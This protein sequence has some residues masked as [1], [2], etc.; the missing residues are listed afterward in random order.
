VSM[1]LI[2]ATA[3]TARALFGGACA[4]V[5]LLLGVLSPFVLFQAGSFLSHPIAGG[6]LAFALAAF[7]AAERRQSG[8]WYA[9]CGVLLG[10]G[11]LAREVAA[12]LFAVPLG[13]RLLASRRWAGLRRVVGF[14]LPLVVV[15]LFYNSGQTGS[16][17]VLPRAIFDPA[18]PFGFGDG[19]VEFEEINGVSGVAVGVMT[20]WEG[21]MDHERLKATLT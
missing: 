21:E 15:Y 11:F 14:G 16:P 19:F 12:V 4:L 13:A 2:A 5:V 9:V 3:W 6:L 10:L 20:R 1:L 17:F 7:V 8:R 18:D